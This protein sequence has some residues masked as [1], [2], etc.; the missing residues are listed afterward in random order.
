MTEN[1]LQTLEALGSVQPAL[2]SMS[3]IEPIPFD[4]A[5]PTGVVE[6]VP[7]AVAVPAAPVAVP[8]PVPE[9]APEPVAVTTQVWRGWRSPQ[10]LTVALSDS[11]PA[12]PQLRVQTQPSGPYVT[13]AMNVVGV[14]IAEPENLAEMKLTLLMIRDI[15]DCLLAGRDSPIPVDELGDVIAAFMPAPTEGV[16]V[17][18]VP[19]LFPNTADNEIRRALWPRC[20]MAML[21]SLMHH[22]QH[23]RV[24]RDTVNDVPPPPTASAADCKH[25]VATRFD[26]TEAGKKRKRGSDRD[27]CVICLTKLRANSQ[28][29]TLACGHVFHAKCIN[30][31]F[32]KTSVTCPMCR[33]KVELKA[34]V[35]KKKKKNDGTAV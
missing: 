2:P 5:M 18:E 27:S 32:M 33:V 23:Q 31:C 9:P 14:T 16:Q 35:L 29:K 26:S 34:P 22:L 20:L 15:V 7:V 10:A 3:D 13:V 1:E 17:D 8:E 4:H 6:E 21:A 28:V 19:F 24:L 11:Q 25:L 30:Q 12:M